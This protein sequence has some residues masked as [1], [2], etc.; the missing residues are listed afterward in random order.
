VHGI[1]STSSTARKIA[2]SAP[3]AAD[4]RLP[5]ENEPTEAGVRRIHGIVQG[6]YLSGALRE[7]D[8]KLAASIETCTRRLLDAEKDPAAA[9]SA[10][11]ALDGDLLRGWQSLGRPRPNA[12]AVAVVVP[13]DAVRVF[14]GRRRSALGPEE[15]AQALGS[16]F[17]PFTVQMQ[18][19]YG[20]TAYLPAVLPAGHA[21]ALPDEI[22]LVFYR[23]QA[24]YHD[25]KA[26]LGGRAYSLL[27]DLVFE[28]SSSGSG[29]PEPFVGTVEADTPYHLFPAP[30]DWQHGAVQVY[31]GTRPAKLSIPDFRHEVASRARRFQ[32]SPGAVDAAIL[33]TAA[34]W[35]ICWAHD[36]GPSA[37]RIVAFQEV[38]PPVFAAA[39]EPRAIPHALTVPYAGF[40]ISPEGGFFNLQ[41]PRD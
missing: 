21:A 15:F 11:A 40:A 17:M 4:P 27:H 23:T 37:A 9:A 38:A 41:F 31:V 2:V 32:Q 10:L 33:C 19:L 5:A 8:A 22:A 3:F 20:L 28:M 18:R 34:D 29:F 12:P 39:A 24:A 14:R 26:C 13:P 35:L 7:R 36:P 30:V 16:L 25:A 6:G 1:F